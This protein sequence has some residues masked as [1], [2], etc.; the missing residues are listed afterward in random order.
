MDKI[1]SQQYNINENHDISLIDIILKIKTFLKKRKTTIL[2]I[3]LLNLSIICTVYYV[4]NPWQ[5][6]L[7]IS[8]INNIFD[9]NSSKS[10]LRDLR[11]YSRSIISRDKQKDIADSVIT[12]LETPNWIERNIANELTLSKSDMR[13]ADLPEQAQTALSAKSGTA[14]LTITIVD[15]DKIMA[16]NQAVL[17]ANAILDVKFTEIFKNYILEQSSSVRAE[18]Q[19]IVSE[20]PTHRTNYISTDKHLKVARNLNNQM[21]QTRENLNANQFSISNQIDT[22]SNS[23]Y[24]LPIEKQLSGL[25]I[26]NKMQELNI[27]NLTFRLSV[28]DKIIAIFNSASE[29]L[30]EKK[31]ALEFA[32]KFS[33]DQYWKDNNIDS[34]LIHDETGWKR[35]YTYDK[36]NL[37][38]IQAQD[39]LDQLRFISKNPYIIQ[40]DKTFSFFKVMAFGFALVLMC[41]L[42]L[43]GYDEFNAVMSRQK[44]TS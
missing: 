41:I 2:T 8:N 5:I 27:D 43:F 3:I 29:E 14:Y 42:L 20:L 36:I 35:S 34:L 24:F 32:Q 33:Q 37:L 15:N 40:A 39:Y 31:S 30:L 16:E 19:K 21:S 23:I 44:Q 25:E 12:K 7:S 4:F 13:T 28:T 22:S 6:K 18:R 38:K 26:E 9:P 11:A 1:I 10:L 17:I